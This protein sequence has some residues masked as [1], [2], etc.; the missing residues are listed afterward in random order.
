MRPLVQDLA[1]FAVPLAAG[2]MLFLLGRTFR[3]WPWFVRCAA[4]VFACSLIAIAILSGVGVRS[5]EIERLAYHAGGMTIVLCLVALFLFGVVWGVPGRS[6]SSPFLIALAAIAILVVAIE[7]S[8]RLW[9]RFGSPETWGRTA[10]SRGLLR[11]SSGVT[12]SPSAAVM[13]LRQHDIQAGEGEMAYLSGTTLLG[14]DATG[15]ARAIDAK[16]APDGMHAEVSQS[17]YEEALRRSAPFLAHVQGRYFGHAVVVVGMQ[18][19]QVTLLDPADGQAHTISRDE[20]EDQWDGVSV[21][22]VK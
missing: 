13:L 21:R 19:D 9:W 7:A 10:D 4:L 6:L 15:I 16:T 14:T 17:T 2:A 3:R 12:C 8:G 1:E 5:L 18:P 22:L 11:Q 20:F